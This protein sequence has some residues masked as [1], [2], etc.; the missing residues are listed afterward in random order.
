MEQGPLLRREELITPG[1]GLAERLLPALGVVEA[2]P[3]DPKR[4]GLRQTLEHRPGTVPADPGRRQLDGQRQ[5][6][7]ALAKRKDVRG[8]F[9]RDLEAG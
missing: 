3:E 4:A 2:V 1:D 9:I 8:G 6:I 7:E 5:S